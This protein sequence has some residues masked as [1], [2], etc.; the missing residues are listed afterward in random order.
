MK[1]NDIFDLVRRLLPHDVNAYEL[2][3]MASK[4][5]W[6]VNPNGACEYV[7]RN[8]PRINWDA[9]LE[10]NQDVKMG[11]VD[12]CQ[13]FLDYGIYEGRKLVSWHPI[14]RKEKPGTPL[15]SLLILVH[16]D[17]LYIGKCL[18]SVLEQTLQ[19]MEIIIVND[20]SVDGSGDFISETTAA[21]EKIKII[22]NPRCIG[23][24]ASFKKAINIASGRYV[25]FMSG[26]DFIRSDT[27]ELAL[28]QIAR[29]WDVVDPGFSIISGTASSARDASKLDCNLNRGAGKVYYSD[30]I[31]K[32]IFYDNYLSW[33]IKGKIVLHEICAKASL[34]LEDGFFASSSDAYI[35]A[36]IAKYTRTMFK[37]SEKIYIYR[38]EDSTN[39]QK[40]EKDLIT[41][42]INYGDTTHAIGRLI[43]KNSINTNFQ[44]IV[45]I[46]CNMVLKKWLDL[47][48]S[49]STMSVID[50]I[51]QQYGI[52]TVVGTC[53]YNFSN[54]LSSIADKLAKTRM[55]HIHKSGGIGLLLDAVTSTPHAD[56]AIAVADAYARMGFS[57]TLFLKHKLDEGI[58]LNPRF[59]I[60]YL[61]TSS[62]DADQ[63]IRQTVYLNNAIQTSGICLM[64]Y[65]SAP[66][67]GALWELL[68][69]RNN[70]VPV[71][72]GWTKNVFE[73]FAKCGNNLRGTLLSCFCAVICADAE[74]E[75]CLRMQGIN[76]WHIPSVA[77]TLDR[78]LNSV[79][80][81][82][83][84]G[85]F[86]DPLTS[87]DN[88]NRCLQV[89]ADITKVCPWIGM[90][91]IGCLSSRQ[92]TDKFYNMAHNMRLQSNI[93]LTGVTSEPGVFL[94]QCGAIFFP[95]CL[96]SGDERLLAVQNYGLPYVVYTG[97][98]CLSH[99]EDQYMLVQASNHI[100][101][102]R[103]L[104]SL[105]TDKNLWKLCANRTIQHAK[106][107]SVKK[108]QSLLLELIKNFHKYSPWHSTRHR[109][110]TSIVRAI[111]PVS[112]A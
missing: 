73:M 33:N 21:Y 1:Q 58:K 47:P 36:A 87:W 28:Q 34:D 74:A 42:I 24:V 77:V 4:N 51:I 50:T 12:P 30:E 62:V 32:G 81:A 92:M 10:V 19:N 109:E 88:I 102:A 55:D 90:T 89:L 53:V 14:K 25:M 75:L 17:I 52:A 27:C 76:A 78:D 20:A 38:Y 66:R 7:L 98:A 111:P 9:Y 6:Q 68:A 94:E 40:S 110:Y 61:E 100:Q 107:G 56:Y 15:I 65:F 83:R 79:N 69:L 71:I 3:S 44:S 67:N 59:R 49:S 86:V 82:Q 35:L 72:A 45:N 48:D 93:S 85:V 91:F 8:C 104:L 31:M 108:Q 64:F 57:V 96:E 2:R 39:S 46:N 112:A 54:K 11:G 106:S 16:N 103:K 101:A 99:S 43:N 18:E 84:I 22:S 37:M 80:P 60:V 63:I 70:R 41:E 95:S 5:F 13:H 29:G 97:T 105:L 26:H 23:P